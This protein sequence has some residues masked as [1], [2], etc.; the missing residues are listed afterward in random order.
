MWEDIM[1]WNTCSV[2]W[3][4]MDTL[5][6][7]KCYKTMSFLF[8]SKSDICTM[9]VIWSWREF[10]DI[11]FNII[12]LEPVEIN[13]MK[14]WHIFQ[15]FLILLLQKWMLEMW[16]ENT[17]FFMYWFHILCINIW[18]LAIKVHVFVETSMDSCLHQVAPC[19]T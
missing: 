5:T 1:T 10:N 3:I 12:Y 19:N 7:Y 18:Y 14:N 16:F 11:P 9:G 2:N 4:R 8:C 17:G 13:I 15:L 6:P